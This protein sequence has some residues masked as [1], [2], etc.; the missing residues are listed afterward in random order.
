MRPR[1]I[2]TVIRPGNGRRNNRN[3]DIIGHI[4]RGDLIVVI[5]VFLFVNKTALNI[6][7]KQSVIFQRAVAD[8]FKTEAA[9]KI[10]VK[11]AVI[12]KSL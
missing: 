10:P 1:F 4:G 2:V 11:K 7:K 3:R 5:K 9:L 6:V 12:R 8:F